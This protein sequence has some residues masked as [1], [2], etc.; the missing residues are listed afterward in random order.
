MV[1][2]MG[3]A[4]WAL[5]S[6]LAVVVV[7][8]VGCDE[9]KSG[10]PS[11]DGGAR[12]NAS[13]SANANA[14]QAVSAVP[15]C[16]PADVGGRLT[17]LSPAALSLAVM[18]G[19]AL[20][21]STSYDGPSGA[22]TTSLG[23][24]RAERVVLGFAGAPDFAPEPIT[25]ALPAADGVS[26]FGAAVALG[27]ELTTI[28]YGSRRPTVSECADGAL[29]AK[30]AVPGS[31]RRELLAHFC[32]PM[33]TF[34]AAA[35]GGVG[36][37]FS[38]APAAGAAGGLEAWVFDAT[39]ARPAAV[40]TL[41]GAAKTGAA[42]APMKV[43]GGRPDGGK[44]EAPAG[45]PT[46]DVPSVAVGSATVAAAYVVVRGASREL[47]VARLAARAGGGPA[48]VEVLDKENVG[49]VT[50]AFEDD[51]L[52]VVWSSFVPDKNRYVLRWSKW[53]ATG[54]PPA[55]QVLG[56]GVLS[57]THP[58]LAIDHG[59]FLLAWAEGD[60]KAATLVKVGASKNG[61]AFIAGLANAVSTAGVAAR[62]PVVALE[63]DTAFVAW[64][65]LGVEPQV[66]AST[67]K[68][69]E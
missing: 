36:I 42:P 46:V 25:D 30:S 10:G 31:A 48:K 41:T 64:K 65:E 44:S 55:T 5:R 59:R 23:R 47:H 7:A 56:T 45:P 58:S 6:V 60:D 21:V 66:R 29:V 68:C 63:A 38:D 27:S 33:S 16:H 53:A 32:R 67:I 39:S 52:H 50:T 54:A 51:T 24:A 20:L 19:K 35:R 18:K 57:A 37:A 2:L 62:E 69:Q 43:D 61:L 3:V 28:A 17:K 9:T 14:K 40:E 34:R 4:R 49:S 11:A 12:A 13:A 1:V 8:G 26:T 22:S 15:G